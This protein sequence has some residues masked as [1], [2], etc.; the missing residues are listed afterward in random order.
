[1]EQQVET[2]STLP[3]AVST[4]IKQ[5]QDTSIHNFYPNDSLN[6]NKD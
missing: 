4:L 3:S 1:M 5:H 2:T 6:K